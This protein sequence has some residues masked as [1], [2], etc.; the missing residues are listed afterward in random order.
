MLTSFG[1]WSAVEV[2]LGSQASR[3]ES[4]LIEHR[5]LL[6]GQAIKATNEL[7]F[8]D[9]KM[10]SSIADYLSKEEYRKERIE[11]LFETLIAEIISKDANS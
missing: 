4:L 3:F 9:R 5:L 11:P 10:L 2:S 6:N 1:P 7:S 8:E